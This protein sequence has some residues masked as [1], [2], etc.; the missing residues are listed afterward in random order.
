MA[1]LQFSTDS[2]ASW[3]PVCT[4]K[5]KPSSP[6]SNQAGVDDIGQDTITPVWDGIQN[7]WKREFVDLKDYLGNRL[8]IRFYFKSDEASGDYGFAVDNIRVRIANIL[9]SVPETMG[10][11]Q[12]GI[13]I[14]PNPSDGACE[15]QIAGLRL[16]TRTRLIIRDAAGRTLHE[17][18]VSEENVRLPSMNLKAGCYFLEVGDDAGR[19]ARSKLLYK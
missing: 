14:R 9:T 10:H 18:F 6:F 2:G 8:W 5:T 13:A 12:M 1:S 16:G 19:S 7:S 3:I 17:S 4:N 11:G 15:I